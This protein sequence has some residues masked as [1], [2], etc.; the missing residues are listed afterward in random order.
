MLTEK[1]L[2]DFDK[3]KTA[4]WYDAEGFSVADDANKDKLIAPE[5]IRKLTPE[6]E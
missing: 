3:T 1:S 6:K 4:E 2:S 5:P